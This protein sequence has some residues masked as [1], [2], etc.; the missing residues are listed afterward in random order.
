MNSQDTNATI[1]GKLL[2]LMAAA[3]SATAANLYYNQPLLPSIGAALGIDAQNL[4]LI[5]SST[6]IGYAA[7]IFF[8]SPYNKP[9]CSA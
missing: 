2:F 5:P 7:A 8:I 1:S 6:Q 9:V 3:I 4:G